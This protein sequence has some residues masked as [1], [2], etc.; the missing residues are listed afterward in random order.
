MRR[1]PQILIILISV[2][3]YGLFV[4]TPVQAQQGFSGSDI[5]NYYCPSFP[6]LQIQ[7]SGVPTAIE[8]RFLCTYLDTLNGEIVT[9][10]AAPRPPQLRVLEIWFMRILAIIWALSGIVF[11]FLLMWLGFK[12]MTAF[13]NK[14]VIADVIK[15]FRKWVIGLALIFLSYPALVTFFRLL[16][17]SRTDCFDE[18]GPGFQ[19]FFPTACQSREQQCQSYLEGTPG[20]AELNLYELCV[21]GNIEPPTTNP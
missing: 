19:F 12:Y 7:G 11:T 1:I 14:Y 10:D 17:L 16:P 5:N 13:G 21:A 18:I 4:T 2:L 8:G 15:D 6:N 9:R 3:V 20:P